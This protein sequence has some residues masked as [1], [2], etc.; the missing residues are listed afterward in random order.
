MKKT[1]S[2]HTRTHTHT[3]AFKSTFVIHSRLTKGKHSTAEIALVG[4]G[5]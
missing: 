2:T 3:Q 4:K 5:L 1:V